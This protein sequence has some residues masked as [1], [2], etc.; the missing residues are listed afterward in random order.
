MGGFVRLLV[1]PVLV[2]RDDIFY[3]FG[4]SSFQQSYTGKFVC[5]VIMAYHAFDDASRLADGTHVHDYA[6]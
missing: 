3:L 1:V 2:V 6:F 5:L 4:E